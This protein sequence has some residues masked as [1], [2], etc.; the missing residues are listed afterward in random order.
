MKALFEPDEA[1]VLRSQTGIVLS[2]IVLNFD[3][4]ASTLNASHTP[5]LQYLLYNTPAS[6]ANMTSLDYGEAR[7]VANN[8][9]EEGRKRNRRIDVVI[10]PKG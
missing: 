2:M 9:S 3:Q 5:L 10:Y 1:I 7:P 4:G 8:E 6:P